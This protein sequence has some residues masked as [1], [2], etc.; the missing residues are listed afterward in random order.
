MT[1]TA[2]PGAP[3]SHSIIGATVETLAT[4][5]AIIVPYALVALILRLVMARAFF[6][7][8]QGK[9]EGPRIPLHLE[10]PALDLT[11]IDAVVILPREIKAATYQMFATQ[12]ASVPVPPAVAANVW[13]YAEFVLPICLVLGF[14]TRFAALALLDRAA[15]ALCRAGAVV[16]GARLRHCDPAHAHVARSGRARARRAPG[17]PLPSRAGGGCSV[18]ARHASPLPT[19]D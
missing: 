7:S 18:G 5:C 16:A 2:T 6:L 10:L 13:S 17:R 8:G 19:T 9:I 4:A 11:V 14:A 1:E 12:F 3:R 15:R